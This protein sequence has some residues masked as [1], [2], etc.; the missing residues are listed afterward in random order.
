MSVAKLTSPVGPW[1]GTIFLLD[2]GTR[3]L[4]VFEVSAFRSAFLLPNEIGTF[5]DP[6]LPLTLL[7]NFLI[8]P[9]RR[10]PRHRILS[11]HS[12]RRW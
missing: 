3:P 12:H 5:A 8:L 6:T 11:E 4:P 2:V 9:V 7:T 10:C 1:A